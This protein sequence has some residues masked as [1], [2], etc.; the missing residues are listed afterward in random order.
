M[1]YR[2]P[3][4]VLDALLGYFAECHSNTNITYSQEE[5]IPITV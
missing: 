2:N 1:M 4:Y 3:N 5:K